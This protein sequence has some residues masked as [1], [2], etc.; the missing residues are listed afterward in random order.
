MDMLRVVAEQQSVWGLQQLFHNNNGCGA[1]GGGGGGGDNDDFF[2]YLQDRSTEYSKEGKDWKFSIIL[3]VH[4]SPVKS[5]LADEVVAKIES[6][7]GQGPYFMPAA[8][9]DV[10]TLDG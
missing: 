1:G 8:M 9:G 3:A 6:M 2:S 10:Q 7:V 4:L 5:L